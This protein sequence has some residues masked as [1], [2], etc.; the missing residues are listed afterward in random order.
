MSMTASYARLAI[1]VAGIA[2]ANYRTALLATALPAASLAV[3]KLMRRFVPKQRSV[4]FVFLGVVTV[5]VFLGIAT[6]ARERFADIGTTLDK[7]A[8]LIQPPESFTRQ[9]TRLFSGRVYLWSRYID[10]YLNGDIINILVGFGPEAWLDRFSLYA[11]NT[12][13]SYLYELGVFGLAAFVWLLISN[14]LTALRT[15]GDERLVLTSCHIGFFVLNLATMPIWT[16]EGAILYALLLSQ[17]WYLQSIRAVHIEVSHHL[18]RS[19]MNAYGNASGQ[20]RYGESTTLAIV[21][22]K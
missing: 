6:L 2:L 4:V 15:R 17:T 1:S 22:R 5:F 14:F 18:I 3:S 11:H 21:R 13:I 12:F 10:A 19:R 8:S 16:L 7:G 9:E 20:Q